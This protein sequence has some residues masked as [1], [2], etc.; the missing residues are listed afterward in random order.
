MRVQKER[1]AV[2][3]Q[4]PPRWLPFP[5]QRAEGSPQDST[6]TTTTTTRRRRRRKT[7]AQGPKSS[8]VHQLPRQK[9]PLMPFPHPIPRE[10]PSGAGRMRARPCSLPPVSAEGGGGPARTRGPRSRGSR[11]GRGG[12]R[13]RRCRTR[14]PGRR[15]GRRARTSRMRRARRRVRVARRSGTIPRLRQPQRRPQGAGKGRARGRCGASRRRR[16]C[17]TGRE[18][19]CA[20]R[21]RSATRG[22]PAMMRGV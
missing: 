3:P 22:R 10:P 14:C 2:G 11:R 8:P 12:T 6:T 21:R 18:G 15:M 19:S 4:W 17:P 9:Q 7:R 1:G 20:S 16:A 13:E 5:Q